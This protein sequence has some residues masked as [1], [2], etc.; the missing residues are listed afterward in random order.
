VKLEEAQHQFI[1]SWGQLGSSWGI[2][3]TM[4][5]IHALLLLSKESLSTDEVMEK[6][7]ISRGNANMNLRELIHWGIVHKEFKP[8]ERKEYFFSEKS[9]WEL[10]KQ[11]MKERKRRELDPLMKM[12]EQ[13]EAVEGQG[14]DVK[15]F[16]E[17][18]GEVKKFGKRADSLLSLVISMKE[19]FFFRWMK[20]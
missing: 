15:L 17:V 12:L 13:V 10:A 18:T 6:L 9:I 3:K 11:V 8:G 14:E 1:Q 19:S 5:Q 4:A 16:K 2:N 7:N 20:K